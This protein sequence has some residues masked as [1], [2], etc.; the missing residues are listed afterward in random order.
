MNSA[1]IGRD[2]A[3]LETTLEAFDYI[4]AVN[5][6][7][8]FIVGQA[9]ARV[10]RTLSGGSIVNLASVSGLVGNAVGLHMRP[11]RGAS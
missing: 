9:A 4:V 8:S 1:G 11:R 5:L 3:F 10:M 2:V 7:G 6:R